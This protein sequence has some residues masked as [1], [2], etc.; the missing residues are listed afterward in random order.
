MERGDEVQR[1][2]PHL[3]VGAGLA[4]KV[5]EDRLKRLGKRRGLER[6]L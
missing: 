5:V 3:V 4:V 6:L 1:A 2:F